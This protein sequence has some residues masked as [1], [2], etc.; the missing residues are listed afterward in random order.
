MAS[1]QATAKLT[2]DRRRAMVSE[3]I[4][5]RPGIT[6]RQIQSWLA[7]KIDIKDR[8]GNVI[9]NAPRL[10]NPDTNKPFV[11]STINEDVKFIRSLWRS[12]TEKAAGEWIA[13]QL[14]ALDEAEAIAWRKGN[15]AEIRMIWQQRSKLLGLDAPIKIAETNAAGEDVEKLN[16]IRVIVHDDSD[17]E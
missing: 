1:K 11:L 5:K 16:V 9:N 8:L 13:R 12:F 10:T 3:L 2:K 4:I 15:T 6:Q 17:A 7:E 14:A